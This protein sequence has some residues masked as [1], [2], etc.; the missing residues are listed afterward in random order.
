MTSH[1]TG[2]SSNTGAAFRLS[3]ATLSG[4]NRTLPQSL[5]RLVALVVGL[6]AALSLG[7]AGPGQ[8]MFSPA[9]SAETPN[10]VIE[11]STGSGI[12]VGRSRQDIDPSTFDRAMASATAA[13]LNFVVVV[14][15][16]PQPSAQ[17]FAL[18]VRQAG[19]DIDAVLLVDAEGQVFTSVGEDY[20]D[21]AS[22]AS[23]AAESGLAPG[24]AAS[25]FVHEL[26]VE[27]VVER[28]ALFGRIMN[29]AAVLFAVLAAVVV[30]EMLWRLLRKRLSAG[31]SVASG[32]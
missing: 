16:D 25:A 8:T 7:A 30:L 2:S 6:F 9:A 4:V 17:A 10:E 5:T 22:R 32:S 21:A 24:R 29:Y 1:G 19:E 31:G 23:E 27:L 12:Y 18:R 28:P 11:A 13:G 14:P 26:T 15:D 3:R 20:S